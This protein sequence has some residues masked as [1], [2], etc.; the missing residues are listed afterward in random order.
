MEEV[1][2]SLKNVSKSFEKHKKLNS[3][4]ESFY[5]F[6]RIKNKEK[7]SAVSNINLDVKKG[8]ILGI[9]GKNGSGKSTLINLI[10]GNLKPDKGEIRSKGKMIRL[11]LGIGVD[12][13]LTG[14]ENIYLNGSMIGLTFK[15]IGE[16]FNEIVDFAGISD[17]IDTPVKYYSKGM[18]NR[19]LFSIAIHTDAEI[20]LLDEFFGGVGDEDFKKKSDEAFK[21]KILE[22]KTVVLVSH[23]KAIIKKHCTRTLWVYNGK[24]KM[25]GNTEDVLSQY[26]NYFK[27]K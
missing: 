1:V 18:L 4:H 5:A 25:L 24:I 19:L 22:N 13:N 12:K 20:I 27:E 17:F 16:R 21:S 15:K 2:I 7:I 9:I 8:E 26:N 11:T 6:F 10:M 23:I 14:R 3:F